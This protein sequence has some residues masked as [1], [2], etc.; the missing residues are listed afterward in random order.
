MVL[1]KEKEEKNKKETV[2]TK[3]PSTETNIEDIFW[4]MSQVIQRDKE[5]MGL[6]NQN[7]NLVKAV[8]NKKHERRL[9]ENKNKELLDKNEKLAKQLSRQLQV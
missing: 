3:K 2:Q 1:E 4:D 6:K 5:I 8:K 7:Q 9:L